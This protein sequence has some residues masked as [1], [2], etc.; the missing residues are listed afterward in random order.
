MFLVTEIKDEKER[1]QTLFAVTE[2]LPQMN[3]DLLERLVFHLAKLVPVALG[4]LKG[5]YCCSS[6]FSSKKCI[7]GRV[8]NRGL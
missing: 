3:H 6:S 1:I 8:L 4:G 2:K 7:R 5:R